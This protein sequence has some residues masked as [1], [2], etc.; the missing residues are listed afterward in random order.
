MGIGI[1]R[2]N[3][4]NLVF[5]LYAR[6]VHPE[7]F[8]VYAEK[9]LWQHAY[10]AVIRICES[11]HTISFRYRNQTVTELTSTREHVLPQRKRC[12]EKRLRGHRDESFRFEDGL[13]YQVSYQ[14]EQL[15]PDVFL[16]FHE[17][18]MLDCDRAEVAYRFSAGNRLS[19]VPLSLVRADADTKSLLIHA[20]HT[21]PECYAVV[22]TQSLFE[23]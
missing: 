1:A 23:L 13:E 20:F 16:N 18:L 11:G 2:T 8:E 21:F 5:H 10:S 4:S 15:E 3:V 14:L 22:K 7:L 6:S 9:E 19:P 17:E 12:L